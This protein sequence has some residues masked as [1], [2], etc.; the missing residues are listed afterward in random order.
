MLEHAA[1]GAAEEEAGAGAWPAEGR[2][3]IPILFGN[4]RL[5]LNKDGHVLLEQKAVSDIK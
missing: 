3:V 5:R 4:S 1:A 2:L